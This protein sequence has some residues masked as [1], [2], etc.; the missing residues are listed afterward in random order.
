VGRKQVSC[1][2]RSDQVEFQGKKIDGVQATCTEC[3]H[4]EE[5]GGTSE[6]SVK[7]CLASMNENCPEDENNFYVA[8]Q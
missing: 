4:V 1:E 6:R 5:A 8:D 2:V 7:R 3:G